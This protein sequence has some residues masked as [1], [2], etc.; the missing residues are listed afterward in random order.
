MKPLEIIGSA[1][2]VIIFALGFIGYTMSFIKLLSL[3]F[4][5]PY[6]AEAIYTIG[7]FTGTAV[8]IGYLDIEDNPVVETKTVVE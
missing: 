4:E 6:R 1:V 7:I 5:K 3:D 8:V 2:G